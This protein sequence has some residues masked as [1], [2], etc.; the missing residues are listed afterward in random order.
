ML[1]ILRS[2][3]VEI[4]AQ[5]DDLYELVDREGDAFSLYIDDP[6]PSEIVAILYR[7][8]GKLHHF[9]ITALVHPNHRH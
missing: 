3:K 1:G 8:F 7:R 4:T 5:G 6:V 2:H 9:Q